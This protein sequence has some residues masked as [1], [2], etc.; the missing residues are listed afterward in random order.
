MDNPIPNNF[1][2]EVE[3]PVKVTTPNR[4]NLTRVA[5]FN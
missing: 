1:C 5:D 4:S 2:I 3:K